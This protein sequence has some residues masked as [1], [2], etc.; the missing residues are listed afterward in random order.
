MSNK[1]QPFTDKEKQYLIE[2]YCQIGGTHCAKNLGRSRHCIQQNAKLLNLK[3]D[4]GKICQ[5]V[6]QKDYEEFS[7]NP[8]PFIESKNMTPIH[9]YLL[10]LIWADGNISKNGYTVSSRFVESDGS[11]LF[12]IFKK[13]GKWNIY[14]TKPKS[15]RAGK[16]SFVVYT[17]NKPLLEYLKSNRYYSKSNESACE[18]LKMIPDNLKH[19]WWQGCFDGDGC[20]YVSK[21]NNG[22]ISL[23]SSYQQDWKHFDELSKQLDITY[24]VYKRNRLIKNRPMKSS[25]VNISSKE[26]IYK[27]CNYLYPNGLEF[28]LKRKFEKAKK[29]ISFFQ[30][31]K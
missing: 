15:K 29:L 6:F 18:I 2:N 1:W 26:N 7:V 20:F 8:K 24:Q 25:Y 23:H 12:P 28:G 27:L 11:D 30:T 21:N 4:R 9:V 13:S 10:G 31:P 22:Q 17:S 19:Y 16:P 5:Y 3:L 14:K